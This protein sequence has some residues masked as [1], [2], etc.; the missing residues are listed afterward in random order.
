MSGIRASN[1][2]WG[3]GMQPDGYLRL[4]FS[5]LAHRPDPSFV[6]G[7]MFWVFNPCNEMVISA[8]LFAFWQ[9]H[10][11]LRHIVRIRAFF[12]LVLGAVLLSLI[13]KKRFKHPKI[14]LRL[15]P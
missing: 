4:A 7:S 11:K 5:I 6:R 3:D 14:N 1:N 9:L 2:D 12:D 15:E 10:S 8:G 13:I